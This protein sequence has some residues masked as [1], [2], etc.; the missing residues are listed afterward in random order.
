MHFIMQTPSS[1]MTFELSPNAAGELIQ[2]A[3]RYAAGMAQLQPGWSDGIEYQDG[4]QGWERPENVIGED[5]GVET[6]EAEAGS[7]M[8]QEATD[9]P[10]AQGDRVPEP[11][12][13]QNGEDAGLQDTW[14]DGYLGGNWDGT[15][16]D[17]PWPHLDAPSNGGWETDA[18]HFEN[19]PNMQPRM[20]PR[21]S[22]GKYTGFLLV[23]CQHCGKVRGFRAKV[24]TD[25]YICDCGRRTPFDRLVPVY[26]ECK[27]GKT[28][29]YK[30]NETEGIFGINCLE[31]GNP[32]DLEYNAR[33]KMYVTI[34]DRT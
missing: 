5:A 31:C 4:Y 27:C 26:A 22:S 13:V 18:K 12:S 17:A 25:T 21:Y 30:T 10:D 7:G 3:F 24:P 9:G 14:Q 11:G 28:W 29:R 8:Q 20:Q 34:Q 23:R 16:E 33:K 2:A 1:K 6:L 15:S 32:I 19:A